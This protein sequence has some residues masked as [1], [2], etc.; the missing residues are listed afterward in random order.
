MAGI[1]HTRKRFGIQNSA[2]A[3]ASVA[4][5]AHCVVTRNASTTTA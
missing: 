1:A 2:K 3:I 5:I 4:A